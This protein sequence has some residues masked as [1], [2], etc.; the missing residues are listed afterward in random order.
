MPTCPCWR[1]RQQ[2]A[3]IV[4]SVTDAQ[5]GQRAAE[6][7]LAL[8][9]SQKV[10]RAESAAD[11]TRQAQIDERIVRALTDTTPESRSADTNQQHD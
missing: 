4:R 2:L 6:L 11:I 3:S 9:E 7:D 5:R 8:A 10:E 1:I